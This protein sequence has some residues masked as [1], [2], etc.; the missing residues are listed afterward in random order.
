ME[1]GGPDRYGRLLAVSMLPLP[2]DN[3]PSHYRQSGPAAHILVLTAWFSPAL[4]SLNRAPLSCRF[5]LSSPSLLFCHV[6]IVLS[7]LNYAL[8]SCLVLSLLLNCTFCHIF[9]CL[10]YYLTML[11][12][13]VLYC[14]HLTMLFCRVLLYLHYLIVLFCHVLL[15]FT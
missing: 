13:H 2:T 4:S 1:Q 5:T 6:L 10:S 9:S 14:L 7:S 3:G 12:C 11:C 15:F 8:L